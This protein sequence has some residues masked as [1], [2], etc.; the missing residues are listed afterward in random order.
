[1]IPRTGHA[2]VRRIEVDDVAGSG[3]GQ[4]IEEVDRRKRRPSAH[5]QGYRRDVVPHFRGMR[6]QAAFVRTLVEV[7]VA[8]IADGALDASCQQIQEQPWVPRPIELIPDRI[9]VAHV[10]GGAAA[11]D[12]PVEV[13]RLL[14]LVDDQRQQLGQRPIDVVQPVFITPRP[15]GASQRKRGGAGKRFDQT[16]HPDRQVVQNARRK[17]PFAALV[18]KRLGRG[19][20]PHY[21][22]VRLRSRGKRVA[23]LTFSRPRTFCVRRSRPMAN[24]PCGG[25]P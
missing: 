25:Q 17:E 7:A 12:R 9:V 21:G 8:V 2:L 24:P 6:S 13:R 1:M 19:G 20:G 22:R 5:E 14:R 11:P 23:S 18:L 16:M 10:V 4:D 15:A 3:G